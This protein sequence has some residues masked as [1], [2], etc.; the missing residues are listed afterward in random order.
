M[1]VIDSTGLAALRDVW[2]RSRGDGTLVVLADVHAQVVAGLD[3][4]GL[5]DLIGE[6][7]IT[8]NVD[9][10][11]NR[12]RSYLGLPPVARPAFATPTVRREAESP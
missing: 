3:R 2:Q 4:S 8:G 5:W 1:P 11:L 7:N 12:A 9:D 10:A 6:D